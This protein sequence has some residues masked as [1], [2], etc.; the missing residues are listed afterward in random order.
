MTDSAG[1]AKMPQPWSGSPCGLPVG[2]S[3]GFM[4]FFQSMLLAA[5]GAI[6]RSISSTATSSSQ[7][8]RISGHAPPEEIDD[9]AFRRLERE[10]DWAGFAVRPPAATRSS[11]ADVAP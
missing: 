10:L 11:R 8:A 4:A 7:N 3:E 1:A 9:H 2:G 5:G 6:V